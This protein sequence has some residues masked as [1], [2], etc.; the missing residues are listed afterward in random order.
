MNDMSQ[1]KKWKEQKKTRDILRW[2]LSVRV[3]DENRKEMIK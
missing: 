2:M 3:E 1:K